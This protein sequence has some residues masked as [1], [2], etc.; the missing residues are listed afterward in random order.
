MCLHLLS[1]CSSDEWSMLWYYPHSSISSACA[2]TALY[3]LSPFFLSP[4]LSP[5]PCKCRALI[6][7]HRATEKSWPALWL[8][9]PAWPQTPLPAC[10]HAVILSCPSPS[11]PPLLRILSRTKAFTASVST[12]PHR[13][14]FSESTNDLR[15]TSPVA[16]VH[17]TE[18]QELLTQPLLPRGDT[19]R[20][21]FSLSE[22]PP[23]VLSPCCPSSS[24]SFVESC[25]LPDHQVSE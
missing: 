3:F 23:S 25:Q 5:P 10:H 18:P 20:T 14:T 17:S 2:R 4:R 7:T 19:A 15:V 16:S 8:P 12:T 6:L 11:L 9:L 13:W 22:L 24:V 21:A 1:F